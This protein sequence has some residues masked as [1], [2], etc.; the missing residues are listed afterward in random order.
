MPSLSA[1]ITTAPDTSGRRQT[2]CVCQR[3]VGH[4]PNGDRIDYLT[5]TF[6]W[7]DGDVRRFHY[8]P[9]CH[10]GSIKIPLRPR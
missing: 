2:C 6:T 8:H 9:G 7:S 3:S 4:L 10:A 1:V 5:E